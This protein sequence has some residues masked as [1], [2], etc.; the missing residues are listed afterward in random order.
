MAAAQ[1]GQL[2]WIIIRGRFFG[3]LVERAKKMRRQHGRARSDP[4]AVEEIAA[5]HLALHTQLTVLS[6]AHQY[7][8]EGSARQGGPETARGCSTCFF[9]KPSE[10][11][12]VTALK[13]SMLDVATVAF[14]HLVDSGFGFCTAF[15][16][17]RSDVN[18]T[19]SSGA[20]EMPRS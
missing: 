11:A 4:D 5:R 7:L 10:L 9:R 2:R 3:E 16:R 8:P 20:G 13:V 17:L 1:P 15:P 14:T 18:S 19:I 12:S 6:V